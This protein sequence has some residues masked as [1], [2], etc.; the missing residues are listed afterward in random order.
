MLLGDTFKGRKKNGKANAFFA[1]SRFLETKICRMTNLDCSEAILRDG[2][3]FLEVN[4]VREKS[5]VLNKFQF[6]ALIDTR[7]YA[8]GSTVKERTASFTISYKFSMNT[9]EK[10]PELGEGVTSA[11]FWVY[12]GKLG[13]R[14]NVDPKESFSISTYSCFANSPLL[15][16]DL[17]GD[18]IRNGI[19]DRV[20]A[21]TKNLQLAEKEFTRLKESH[22][23]DL[24][25]RHIRKYEKKSKV[26]DY[27]RELTLLLDYEVKVNNMIETFK[28]VMRDDYNYF[29]ALKL[30][31]IID[32][33]PNFNFDSEMTVQQ[34]DIPAKT[35]QSYNVK[36]KEKSEYWNGTFYRNQINI[37]LNIDASESPFK[38][39]WLANEFGD[40]KYFFEN[41]RVKD[42]LS[43]NKWVLSAGSDPY[44]YENDETGAGQVSF[45]YQRLFEQKY[46]EY[47]KKL[48]STK[49]D[50]T[51]WLIYK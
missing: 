24:K 31:I 41:V 43:Y 13:R 18:T 33:D 4:S 50:L 2:S 5:L 26:K 32:V 44:E 17:L 35:V 19:S 42:P 8:F 1:Q 49:L 23:G 14:W 11:E 40:V 16:I 22:K 39:N 48:P 36:T 45:G 27:R 25:E 28:Q 7:S 21:T 47:I 10:E 29:N 37:Y 51:N 12:D 9:Q 30:D 15:Y 34:T 38:T 46:L 20:R 3:G 6:N